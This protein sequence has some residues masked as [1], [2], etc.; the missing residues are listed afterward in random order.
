MYKKVLDIFVE[1]EEPMEIHMYKD[2]Y[3]D[4]ST[5]VIQGI[6]ASKVQN[7]IQAIL[8]PEIPME[9]G[10]L[11]DGTIGERPVF[12]WEDAFLPYL[13]GKSFSFTVTG[14]GL[15]TKDSFKERA[16]NKKATET[17][18]DDFPF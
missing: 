5:A 8:E 9:Q 14:A 16:F 18:Q 17:E 4:D 2:K 13:V 7:I 1:L 3:T 12:D 6:S 11:R 10:K 15:D